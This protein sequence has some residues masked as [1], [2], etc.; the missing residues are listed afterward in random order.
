MII[1]DLDSYHCEIL[2]VVIMFFEELRSACQM[3]V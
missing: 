2:K 3:A 1:V